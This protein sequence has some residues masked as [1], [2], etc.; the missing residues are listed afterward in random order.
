MPLRSFQ[1]LVLAV[2][3]AGTAL[4]AALILWRTGG[5]L[6]YTLDD[7]YI[8]LA[9]AEE[10]GRGGYGINRGAFASPSS[11]MLY[12]P[13]L[14]VLLALGLG[15]GAALVL[16]LAGQAAVL[17]LLAGVLAPAVPRRWAGLAAVLLV[18]AVNGFA[19]PLT[20]MEH[21]LHAAASVA[22]VLGLA[23]AAQGAAPGWV[24]PVILL[25]AALRFEGY[26]LA[27][28]AIVAL[29]LLRQRRA[30]AGAA[31]GLALLTLAYGAAMTAMGLP[32]LPSSVMV[33]SAASAALVDADGRGALVAVI[34]GA[35]RSVQSYP[36]ALLAGLGL[37]LAG[38]ALR[39]PARGAYLWPAFAAVLAH[40]L[41]GRFGWFG[42]YEVYA[43]A[44]ALAAL[45]LTLRLAPMLGL[46][47]LAGA[48]YV[49]VTLQTPGAALAV[50]QQQHQMHR[51]ATEFFPHPVA[52][53][54]LGF[55]AYDNDNPV[56]DLW[57][58]GSEE[59]RR[60]TAAQGRTP[61]TLRALTGGR[62]AWAMIYDIAFAGAVPP[63]WCRV[64]QLATARG[65]NAADTVALYLIDRAREA[66][67]R[68]ALAAFAPTL[69]QGATLTTEPCEG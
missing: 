57:G 49:P 10:I 30:A 39:H 56:L 68:A 69:P 12:A 18:L 16:A 52:V 15:S 65:A 33:K 22:V 63:E 4:L 21:P 37:L 14:A 45:G 46:L 32:L 42:R 26:A 43:M 67:F 23:R 13:L 51:L 44:L 54:D 61:K 7:P 59:A 58:L 19:L 27:L 29:A 31:A 36:G 20:G 50:H 53:N 60:L 62:V 47:A 38:L 6:I 64:G 8:H 5:V 66:E 41:V 1:I 11:S 2:G 9:L 24:V 3:L 35:L 25:A 40:L 34:V 28:A 17:W 55:V 48:A